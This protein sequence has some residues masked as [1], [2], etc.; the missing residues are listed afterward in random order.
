MKNIPKTLIYSRLLI[1]ILIMIFSYIHIDNYKVIAVILFTVGLLTDI[2]D[3]IIARQLNISTQ[4]L[5]RLDSSVD[6]LFFIVILIATYI[7]SPRFFKDNSTELIILLSVEGLTYL[8]CLIKF[9]KEIA[10]HT[11]SS[12]I[13][14]LI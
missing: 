10:T 11:I 1:G 3:G 12:K 5:R 7:E 14:T 8:I 13:W 6:Q 4:N 9:R 2:F